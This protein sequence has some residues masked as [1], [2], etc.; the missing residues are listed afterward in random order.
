[1]TTNKKITK[2]TSDNCLNL[3]EYFINVRQMDLELFKARQTFFDSAEFVEPPSA[4]FV[5]DVDFIKPLTVIK[6]SINPTLQEPTS[7]VLATLSRRL[8][9]FNGVR[10]EIMVM[11]FDR[12]INALLPTHIYLLSNGLYDYRVSPPNLKTLLLLQ[13]PSRYRFRG[14]RFSF[15]RLKLKRQRF[16]EPRNFMYF[17]SFKRFIAASMQ[18]FFGLTPEEESA[19]LP[20]KAELHKFF[21]SQFGNAR[22]LF[23]KLLKAQIIKQG[24]RELN[25]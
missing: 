5:R 23:L 18:T 9:D 19:M 4:E 10:A 1:M 15:D 2:Y 12:A 21:K 13:K 14:K 16:N 11:S 20:F 7:H 6:F 22:L 3:V 17:I 25:P 8:L 24:R